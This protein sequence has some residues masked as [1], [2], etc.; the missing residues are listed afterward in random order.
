MGEP[1]FQSALVIVDSKTL[2]DVSRGILKELE[3]SDIHTPVG[4][5]QGMQFLHEEPNALLV[6]EWNETFTPS[7]RDISP[8]GANKL[9]K[10]DCMCGCCHQFFQSFS[11]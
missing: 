3:V 6:V 10:C 1:A 4:A 7:L 8:T 2:V 9:A 11:V 5:D